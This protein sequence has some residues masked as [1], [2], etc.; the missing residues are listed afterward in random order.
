M[1]LD[2]TAKL[3]DIILALQTMEGIN[4]KA[5]LAS[6]VGSP[7]TSNDTMAAINAVIQQAKNDLAAKLDD[8]SHNT[9]PLL[10]LI[11]RLPNEIIKIASGNTT[12]NVLSFTVAGL[13]FTPTYII[14]R[15]K[16]NRHVY[17]D[18]YAPI[19]DESLNKSHMGHQEGSTY[20]ANVSE[21]GNL[22]GVATKRNSLFE[23]RNDGFTVTFTTNSPN[24][25][26]EWIAIS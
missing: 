2:N 1:P 12:G 5:D 8:G 13:L 24:G 9:D 7:A 23:I 11:D 22:S 25:T 15:S 6:V 20:F 10:D 17:Q 19:G 4:A 21:G 18:V 16:G 3:S 14:V 26:I